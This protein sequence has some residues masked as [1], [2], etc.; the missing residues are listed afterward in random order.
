MKFNRLHTVS[1]TGYRLDKLL[2]LS[3]DI[4]FIQQINDALISS[5]T[6]LIEQG[7][8]TFLTGMSDGFDL[9]AAQSVLKLKTSYP[10][11]QLIAAIPFVNQEVKYSPQDKKLYKEVLSLV[12][13]SVTFADHFSKGAYFLR[14][15][16][17][18]DNSSVLVT[19][20][21]GLKGGTKYT[22]DRASKTG[23]RIIN[24]AP[25]FSYNLKLF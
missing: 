22:Y 1:F 10:Q 16:F 7:Y 12:D 18:V 21:T 2:T 13:N 15:N 24:L 8:I 5:I 23:L 3:D 9:M 6:Q 11:I 19:Y 20:F 14:N 17:L 4:N 25:N